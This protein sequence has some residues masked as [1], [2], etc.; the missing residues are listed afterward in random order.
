MLNLTR[1]WLQYMHSQMYSYPSTLS[2]TDYKLVLPLSLQK[3][4]T[5]KSNCR[6]HSFPRIAP[7][8]PAFLQVSTS[9]EIYLFLLCLYLSPGT[10]CFLKTPLLKA[11]LTKCTPVFLGILC[12]VPITA[13][14]TLQHCP[15]FFPL[16]S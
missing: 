13:I 8:F 14:Q 16:L 9:V 11:C 6:L 1:P 2:S 3:G 4:H 7:E 12:Q 5:N 15:S 10:G